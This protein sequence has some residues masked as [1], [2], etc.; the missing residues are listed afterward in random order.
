MPGP[1]SDS[2]EGPND[3]P[4]PLPS[5]AEADQKLEPTTEAGVVADIGGTTCRGGGRKAHSN[6]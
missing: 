2:H 4:G 5:W 6:T 1:V 3:T